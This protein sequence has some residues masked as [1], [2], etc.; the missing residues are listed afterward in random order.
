MFKKQCVK[1]SLVGTMQDTVACLEYAQR[2]LLRQ[3]CEVRPMSRWV[4][5]VEELKAGK[6]AGR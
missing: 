3:I 1:G 2:G 6:V 5:S 4:E